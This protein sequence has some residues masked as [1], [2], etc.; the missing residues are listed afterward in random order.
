MHIMEG[1]L[2]AAH[3]LAWSAISA[4]FVIMGARQL[5]KT[6]AERPEAR[7]ELGA[8]GAFAFVLSALKLPSV[9]GSCSHPTGTGLGAM[10]MGPGIMSVMGTIVLVFQ[11]LLLAHGGLTTLG[12]NVFSMA[13]AGPWMAWGAWTLARKLGASASVAVF[14]GATLGDLGTYMVT[15]AQLALAFPDAATGF[16]G[17]L[18]KFAGIFALTQ[19][20]LAVAEG[21][22]TVVVMNALSA[23]TMVKA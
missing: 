22:L 8:A 2:P 11:A 10:T 23:R 5:K 18:A 3:A 21:L 1:F 15:S 17:A 19:L 20:P 14:L 4:P 9:T 12:A 16:G 7:L 13:I 6:L